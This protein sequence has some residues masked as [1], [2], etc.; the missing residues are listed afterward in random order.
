[1]NPI[2]AVVVDDEPLAREALLELL[3]SAQGVE[4]VG[5]YRNGSSFLAELP[6]LHPDLV[7]LDIEMPRLSGIDVAVE[8]QKC[9]TPPFV[10][11]VTA[12]DRYA[13]E[14]FDADVTDYLVKPFDAERLAR[15]IGRVQERKDAM[16]A[17]R[18]NASSLPPAQ[19][20]TR[21]AIKGHDRIHL[22]HINDVDWIESAD[23]YVRL[24]VGNAAYSFR[25]TMKAMEMRLDPTRFV[26][27][28]RAAIVNIDRVVS[29]QSSFGREHVVTL[30]DGT[31]LRLSLAYRARLREMVEGL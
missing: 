29:L 1:M 7:F 25:A 14:A 10:V 2:R 24:H 6:H 15:T 5:E 23:N 4:I 28:D 31:R 22:V 26:R 19:P 21:V 13:V 17:L 12:F 8:I 18:G 3:A 20:L 16:V 9:D 30:R 11:F 27:I